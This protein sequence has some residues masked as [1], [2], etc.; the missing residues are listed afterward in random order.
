M[1]VEIES[2]FGKNLFLKDELYK[3]VGA[4]ISEDRDSSFSS[5]DVICR[6]NKPEIFEVTL[7]KKGS[8]SPFK[9]RFLEN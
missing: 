9:I 6:I 1:E 3:K 7:L 4:K 5:S 2:E 8:A